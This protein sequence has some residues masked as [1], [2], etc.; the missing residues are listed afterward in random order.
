MVQ[1]AESFRPRLHAS[2]ASD[3]Q[4]SEPML[5]PFR[6]LDHVKSYPTFRF[7]GVEGTRVATVA[8]VRRIGS[9]PKVLPLF[10]HVLHHHWL[11]AVT[12]FTLWFVFQMLFFAIVE[13]FDFVWRKSTVYW[14][15]SFRRNGVVQSSVSRMVAGRSCYLFQYTNKV[16]SAFFFRNFKQDFHIIVFCPVKLMWARCFPSSSFFLPQDRRSST[17]SSW[18]LEEIG[19]PATF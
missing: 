14:Q 3:T 15:P 16:S 12:L 6:Y 13:C 17:Q 5:P 1:E 10:A 19:L 11:L 4:R 8:F 18:M 7:G 9:W 2:V